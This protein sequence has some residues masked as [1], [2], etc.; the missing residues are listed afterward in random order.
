MLRSAASSSPSRYGHGFSVA[1]L[2]LLLLAGLVDLQEINSNK[3]YSRW[4]SAELV[5]VLETACLKVVKFRVLSEKNTASSSKISNKNLVQVEAE[6]YT[7]ME[8]TW[9]SIFLMILNK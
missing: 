1:H 8:R 5:T 3:K 7:H 6:E 9:Q 4:T 2:P